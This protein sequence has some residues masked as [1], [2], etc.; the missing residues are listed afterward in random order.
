M[1]KALSSLK[2]CASE[3]VGGSEAHFPNVLLCVCLRRRRGSVTPYYKLLLKAARDGCLETWKNE[4]NHSMQT[5]PD[6]QG[7]EKKIK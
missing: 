6:R 3:N 1:P 2:F 4:N 7:S 5:L